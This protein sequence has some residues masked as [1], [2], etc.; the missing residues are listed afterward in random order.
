MWYALSRLGEPLWYEYFDSWLTLCLEPPVRE[1]GREVGRLL[2]R[3]AKKTATALPEMA[4]ATKIP[5][6]L[7]WASAAL[8]A[9]VPA[10]GWLAGEGGFVAFGC[11]SL[12]VAGAE[13]G[14]SV[15]GD[16]VSGAALIG[17]RVVGS[18]V[19]A[20]VV[21]VA[22]LGGAVVGVAVV[23]A[24]VMGAAVVGEAVVGLAV[25][26]LAVVG[27][28]VAVVGAAVITLNT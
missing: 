4:N 12:P 14:C 7:G 16:D 19:G 28:A 26:G 8:E 24:T 18:L 25:V 15:L 20:P 17:E 27:L 9:A 21:G 3:H 5:A 6:L 1:V 2:M 22:V 13:L 11:L 10:V 23:G